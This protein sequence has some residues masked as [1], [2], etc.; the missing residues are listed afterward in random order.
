MSRS[1][2]H[3]AA[4]REFGNVG[5]I[6]EDARDARGFRVV[7]T[8]IADLRFALRYFAR[9][10]ATVAI[11][12]VVLALG[13]GANAM[14]SSIFQAEFLRPAPAVPD[15]GAQARVWGLER[16]TTRARWERA[17][18]RTKTSRRSPGVARS[19]PPSPRGPPMTSSSGAATAPERAASAH[20]S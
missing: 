3:Y 9:H 12:V 11:I 19:L 2:A 17:P 5:V 18:S 4:L 6:E 10:K 15:D 7:E 20:S 13:T 16:A 14:I 8:V 1:D